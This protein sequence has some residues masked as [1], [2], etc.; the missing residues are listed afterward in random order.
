MRP[1]GK[2]LNRRV[3]GALAAVGLMAT[4]VAVNNP[5]R[6]VHDEG[7]A[8]QGDV[9][10]PTLVDWVDFFN[11][12]AG[13]NATVKASLPAGFIRAEFK[14]DYVTPDTT[15]YATG[16]KDT[17]RIGDGVDGLAATGNSAWQCKSANNLGSKFDLLNAYT[18]AFRNAA[19]HLIVYFGSEIGSP[20]GDRNAGLW[21]LQ[22]T[23]VGCV[24]AGNTNFA[25][26][27]R[28]GDVFIVIAFT[29]GGT[30]SN[31]TVYQ[32]VGDDATG[33]LQLKLTT[34]DLADAGA[35][36]RPST[37]RPSATT[38]VPS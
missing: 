31:I 20:N 29:N 34:G 30:R 18:T 16:S 13:G 19:N 17:L 35:T 3:K 5:A 7:F 36:T 8:L 9:D 23:A 21:L 12:D 33:S 11:V 37:C 25:G 2:L 27:H 26:Q 1:I 10:H 4:V 6:A 28:D 22:D 32:W 15:A 24:G 38:P 14:A